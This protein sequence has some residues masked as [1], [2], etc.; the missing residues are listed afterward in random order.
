[1]LVQKNIKVVELDVELV[2]R[3]AVQLYE[4]FGCKI[5]NVIVFPS[6]FPGDEETFS[7]MR[8]EFPKSEEQAV[9]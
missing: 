3:G 5:A 1:M 9:S 6:D 2:S 4:K 8:L 7:N